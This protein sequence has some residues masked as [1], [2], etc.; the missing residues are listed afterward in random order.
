[1]WNPDQDQQSLIKEFFYGYYG[2]SGKY[3]LEYFNL[4]ESSFKKSGLKLKAY[5]SD[6]NF[7]SDIDI[8]YANSLFVKALSFAA[9]DKVFLERVQTEKLSFDFL[10]T[11]MGKNTSKE[12]GAFFKGLM[13]R[14]YENVNVNYALKNYNLALIEEVE[15]EDAKRAVV[16]SNKQIKIE[17]GKFV[18]YRKGYATNIR[19]DEN[20]EDKLAATISGESNDWAIQYILKDLDPIQS[21]RFDVKASLRVVV[22]KLS[23]SNSKINFGVYDPV[24]NKEVIKKEIAIEKLISSDYVVSDLGEIELKTGYII[25]FS[26]AASKNEVDH[27][28]IDNITLNKK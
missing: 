7:I 20:A 22:K 11:Y 5:H 9:K 13:D 3:L 6:Y 26:I 18:F 12:K 24:L 4:I 2:K 10:L 25:W 1:M 16:I 15:T 21:A 8:R 27:L 17:Q 23:N 28:F 19:Y 14:S